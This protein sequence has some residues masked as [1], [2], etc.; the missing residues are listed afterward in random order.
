MQ[1]GSRHVVFLTQC[2]RLLC[3]AAYLRG[4]LLTVS[5]NTMAGQP[6]CALIVHYA[7]V[8][9]LC[10]SAAVQL[11][12]LQQCCWCTYNNAAGA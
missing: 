1:L 11:L 10:T 9:V 8:D 3:I 2:D 7:C 12:H 6:A 5:K 4:L